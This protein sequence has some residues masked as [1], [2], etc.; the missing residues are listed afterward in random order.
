MNNKTKIALW[1]GR[2]LMGLM[3]L[4]AGGNKLMGNPMMVDMFDKIGFGQG[5]RY[6]TG[7]LEV[8]TAVLIVMPRTSFYGAVIGV[9]ILIGAFLTQ[10]MVMHGD[11]IHTIVIGAILI[12]LAWAQRPRGVKS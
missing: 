5:F 1:V 2:V 8:L 10:L 11:V 4:A 9:C 12:L 3:F 7:A 6:F